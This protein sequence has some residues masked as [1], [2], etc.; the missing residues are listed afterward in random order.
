MI[1]FQ[2]FLG[3]KLMYPL[4]SVD[5]EVKQR[6]D[7]TIA[8]TKQDIA[9]CESEQRELDEQMN[10]VLEE[11]AE[12]KKRHVCCTLVDFNGHNLLNPALPG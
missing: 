8:S 12:F 6:I 5:P 1:A 2:S 11:D 4:S 3:L 9:M 10:A 7:A